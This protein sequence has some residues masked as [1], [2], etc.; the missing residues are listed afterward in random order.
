[1][2][3]GLFDS[4]QTSNGIMKCD[5]FLFPWLSDRALLL[6][7]ICTRLYSHKYHSLLLPSCRFPHLLISAPPN[8]KDD[9]DGNFDSDPVVMHLDVSLT[10]SVF[11]I[12]IPWLQPD[13][14]HWT[15][16]TH[17]NHYGPSLGLHSI[18][19]G[20]ALTTWVQGEAFAAE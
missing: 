16:L 2:T 20:G 4:M 5:L 7:F 1:M 15:C 9:V 18:S 11:A 6:L 12:L 13:T 19:A 10:L 3:M 17:T 8:Y 14:R